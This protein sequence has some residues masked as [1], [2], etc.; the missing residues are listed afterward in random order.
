[1][2]SGL[3]AESS[4]RSLLLTVEP[5]TRCAIS[6]SLQPGDNDPKR[7]AQMQTNA[8]AA[9][10]QL[11]LPVFKYVPGDSLEVSVKE[12]ANYESTNFV[13]RYSQLKEGAQSDKTPVAL[14]VPL[15]PL[16]WKAQVQFV[17]PVCEGA[18]V[19][20]AN[21]KQA[22]PAALE[23]TRKDKDPQWKPLSVRLEKEGFEPFERSYTKDEI[24]KKPKLGS[25]YQ[26]NAELEPVRQ[27]WTLLIT[28]SALTRGRTNEVR[29]RV[30]LSTNQFASSNLVGFTP[31]NVLLTFDRPSSQASWPT[32]ALFVE[33]EKYEYP[34]G[35]NV[36]PG[37]STN[38]CLATT[39]VQGA[40]L[41]HTSRLDLVQF[42]QKDFFQVPMRRFVYN[43]KE[44]VLTTTNCA[45]ARESQDEKPQR[46]KK[47]LSDP[48][49]GA[50]QQTIVGRMGACL[51]T[52][53]GS[54]QVKIVF[55]QPV[56]RE[57]KIV[58]SHIVYI[59]E[60]TRQNITPEVPGVYD[61]DPAITRDDLWV[62][63]ASNREGQSCI[64][65]KRVRTGS[66]VM[67]LDPGQGI[68]T[69]PAV[70]SPPEGQGQ[71]RVAFT[72]YNPNAGPDTPPVIVIQQEDGYSFART[73]PGSLPAWS[74]DGKQVAY[75]N[76]KKRICT[77][78]ADG[79]PGDEI[80]PEVGTIDTSPVWVPGDHELIYASALDER[81]A[82]LGKYNLYKIPAK[83]GDKYTLVTDGSFNSL[84]MAL[85]VP[86]P[87]KREAPPK[88]MV[89]FLSSREATSDGVDDS[90]AVYFFDLDLRTKSR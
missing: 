55:A 3:Q 59:T 53:G 66:S 4:K 36:R 63:Y 78:G 80:S 83:G 64:Y 32:N 30:F 72:R 71:P 2:P 16:F 5:P 34:E 61:L 38:Y 51:T 26:V 47:G 45:S 60:N 75:V 85:L 9:D 24:E 82:A 44:M 25:A 31:T 40:P 57:A 37:F 46:F 33:V 76:P 20:V 28:T 42:N 13:I 17:G 39:Y 19:Y 15:R 27:S 52:I 65:K 48:S 69:E 58:G 6:V 90:W 29:G 14:S 89:Y 22:S 70:Y 35:T 81:Q 79:S 62:Y 84:P 77:L 74:N 1:M 8:A 43:G 56:V 67:K 41:H 23:F 12:A 10:G 88:K 54:P 7:A 87:E 50:D 21:E 68:D 73:V 11:R 18:T 49:A 86:D